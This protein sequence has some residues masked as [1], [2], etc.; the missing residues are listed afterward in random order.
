M[1]KFLKLKGQLSCAVQAASIPEHPFFRTGEHLP[2][3]VPVLWL[4][5]HYGLED[6]LV[7]LLAEGQDIEARNSLGETALYRASLAGHEHIVRLLLEHG[8]D[9]SARGGY[10]GTALHAAINGSHRSTLS[11]LL[12]YGADME[13]Q[14]SDSAGT[15]L[16]DALL[17][18]D[19]GIAAFILD[20]G[21]NPNAGLG[22][23]GNALFIAVSRVQIEMV[24]KLL[25]RGANP[26]VGLNGFGNVLLCAISM[27]EI[28]MVN[29]LLDRG[30]DINGTGLYSD[31]PL[32]EAVERGLDNIVRLLL[33]RGADA[34]GILGHPV[35]NVNLG[36]VRI[37]MEKI[38]HT[39][40]RH[41]LLNNCL[42][43]AASE[44]QYESVT[45]LL[46]WGAN[47]HTRGG[48]YDTVLQA[49]ACQTSLG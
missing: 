14:G 19:Q 36:L 46:D 33:E 34:E 7:Q 43:T 38:V 18:G 39:E 28:E 26:N 21:A 13:W 37:L 12:N 3:I 1:L 44:G 9:V 11:T 22:H 35:Y 25:D 47:I 27:G 24:N 49:A 5:A 17:R 40:K 10:H 4:A 41:E 29:M 31:N 48:E 16:Q 45:L 2:R 8:A 42:I 32:G 15:A 20:R 30:A 6:A 23:R